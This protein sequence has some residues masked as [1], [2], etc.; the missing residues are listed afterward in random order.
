MVY[1]EGFV[2]PVPK[3][4]IAKYRIMARKAGKIWKKHGALQFL[5]CEGDDL[6]PD[7]GEVKMKTFLQ[8]SKTKPN[9]TVVFA[10]ITYKTKKHRQR[11]NAKVMKDPLMNDPEWL[12]SI[13]F[14][15]KRM[16]YG[17]FKVIV[18]L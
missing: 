15:I 11:V 2:I 7:T 17:G 3:K 13:P 9:E 10:F 16:A 12:K 5:E 18:N 8:L 6:K 1:L 4:N 14:D